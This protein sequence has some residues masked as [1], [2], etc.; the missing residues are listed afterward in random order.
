VKTS[1][2]SE[3][4]VGG[5]FALGVTLLGVYTILI[6]GLGISTTKKYVVDFTEIQG[7]KVNDTVRVEGHEVG[8]VVSLRLLPG[9]SIR[10]V[11]E[12]DDDV[13]IYREGSSVRITPFSPLGGRVVE[14]ERGDAET[15][16]G[17]YSF[18]DHPD[19]TSLDEADV[20]QGEAEGEALASLN[21]LI[22]D[23]REN[24][25]ALIANLK[26]ASD[27][28]AGRDSVL[29]YLI[30]DPQGGDKL[31][32]ILSRLQSASGHLDS[33][34]GRVD[35]GQGVLG[36]VTVDGHP[37][38]EDLEGA[39]DAGRG[40]LESAER[41]LDRADRGESALGVL[42]G[43][44]QPARDNLD[45]ILADVKH[46]SGEIS[47]P[48]GSG[49]LT[50]LVHDDRLYEYASDTFENTA[51]ITERVNN[52]EGVLGALFDEQAGQDV[53]DT[54]HNLSEVSAAIND[55]EAGTLGLLIHD[56]VVR[57][58][59]SRI[60]E[61]VERLIVEFRDSLE[62]VREQAPVNAFIGAVFAAF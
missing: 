45:G 58:R 4:V 34:L 21:K 1:A 25:Q 35:Q 2:L 44:D 22:N 57:G 62:D 52:N 32:E 5:V 50:R 9:G 46:I 38:Q 59:I 49:T 26:A 8:E 36:A 24:F 17:S 37:L 56:D 29:G 27:Q 41:I 40:T 14:I 20:I 42:V 55:P 13:Q 33:I 23:N 30:N 3:L 11:L 51:S 54:L 31:E 47:D 61:Q 18:Y 7:L 48:Q 6:S 43:E 10:S 53:K 60:A 39:V 19:G 16:R 12:V 28:L 15:P